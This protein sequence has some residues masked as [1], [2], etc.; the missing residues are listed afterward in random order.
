MNDILFVEDLLTLNIV[1]YGIDIVDGNVIGELAKRSV[2]KDENTVRLLRYNNHI[3]YV[4]NINAVFQS[5]RRPNC[6]NS[7]NRTFNLEQHL[8]T[9]NERVT[10]VYRRNVYQIRE[11][12]FDK[13]DSLGIKYTSEQNFSIFFSNI[14]LRADLCPRKNLQRHKYNNLGRET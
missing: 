3:C 5:F 8:T 9:C 12:L 10:N 2:Q 1:L 14:R 13:L 7:F 11:T 6:D 4:N